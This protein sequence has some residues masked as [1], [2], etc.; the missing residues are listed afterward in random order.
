MEHLDNGPEYRV[1][2]RESFRRSEDMGEPEIGTAWAIYRS[3]SQGEGKWPK[4]ET[5]FVSPTVFSTEDDAKSDAVRKLAAVSCCSDSPLRIAR[6]TA[7]A[8]IV[9]E[10]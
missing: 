1:G 4:V 5:L 6:Q 3:T 8:L 10:S 2:L 9:D 7:I